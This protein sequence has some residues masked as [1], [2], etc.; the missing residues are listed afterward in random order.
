[1]TERRRCVE[2]ISR[3]SQTNARRVIAGL[4]V[5]VC[6]G[7]AVAQ[8]EAGCPPVAREPTTEQ[9]QTGMRDARDRGFLWR[10]TKGGRSSYLYGTMH[11]A[12]LEWMFPGP[13]TAKA[14]NASDT[15]ALEIDV[16]DPEMQKSM[17][18]GKPAPNDRS[19]PAALQARLQRLVRSECLP[20]QSLAGLS[21]ELQVASLTTLAGRRDGLDPA[22]GIDAFLSSWAHAANKPVVSLETAELQ[23]NALK[24]SSA[25]ETIELVES[26]LDDLE[27]G[28]ASASVKRMAQVWADSDLDVLANYE[29]WCECMKTAADRVE[30]KR[31]L[32]DRNPALADGIDALHERGKRVFA[33]VGSLHMIGPLGLPALMAERG[34][35]VRRL[36]HSH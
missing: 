2:A 23:L 3:L 33:A 32:D 4:I 24:M 6:F 25:A 11:V 14:M 15:V 22:F 20:P 35:E 8:T 36:D 5:A 13:A 9:I 18:Q 12:K 28:A 17:S 7:S 16:L 29:T 21:P 19:L 1:M 34:Y 30:M 26:S 27:S 31:L 10:I